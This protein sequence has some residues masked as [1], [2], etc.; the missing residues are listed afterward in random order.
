MSDQMEQEPGPN[1]TLLKWVVGVLGFLIILFVVVIAVTIY[2]RM[3]ATDTTEMVMGSTEQPA[4]GQTYAAFG[5]KRIPVPDD[6]DVISLT[7]SESRLFVM[8]G[9]EGAARLILVVDVATG[10]VVGALNLE[11]DGIQ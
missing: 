8:L 7:A 9:T 5:D 11:K 2:K 1:L 3:T 4:V 6:M 10:D